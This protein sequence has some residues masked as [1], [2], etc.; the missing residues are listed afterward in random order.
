M[1]A[2]VGLREG[3]GIGRSGGPAGRPPG[4]ARLQR[5]VRGELGEPTRELTHE[6]G[7]ENR[8]HIKVRSRGLLIA[9]EMLQA[10]GTGKTTAGERQST[11]E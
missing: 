6:F 1:L 9:R 10:A 2:G 8:G 4:G 7:V 5:E 3:S 11:A